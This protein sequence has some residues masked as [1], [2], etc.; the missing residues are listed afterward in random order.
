MSVGSDRK[1]RLGQRRAWPYVV[2]IVAFALNAALAFTPYFPA[3]KGIWRTDNAEQYYSVLAAFMGVDFALL[4]LAIGILLLD[5][6]GT[7][8]KEFGSELGQVADRL[9]AST[10]RWL[11]DHA[12]YRGFLAA[13]TEAQATVRIA[14]FAPT[15]PDAVAAPGRLGYYEDMA[16]LMR[17]RRD[18]QF[19]LLVRYSDENAPWIL[20]LVRE[21]SG[22]PNVSLAVVAKDLRPERDMGLALS[23]QV[24]DDTRSW[25]VAIESHE[26]VGAHRDLY[27][28]SEAFADAMTRYYKR[29]WANADLVLVNGR[30]TDVVM[31]YQRRIETAPDDALPASSEEVSPPTLGR[32][33]TD[34][35]PDS[36]AN[37]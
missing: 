24:V 26:R 37:T 8:S 18:V 32:S 13:A 33:A 17:S 31:R 11:P 20:E 15:P 1:A 3:T 29:L 2:L 4:T 10:I 5:Q 27:V 16:E 28:E 21:F 34:A 12:F 7:L 22:S 23:V 6:F 36:G 14:Y 25:L 19:F 9:P 35:A 30:P